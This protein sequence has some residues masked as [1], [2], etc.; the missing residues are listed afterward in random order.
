MNGSLLLMVAVAVG[1]APTILSKWRGH[2]HGV[3]IAVCNVLGL[4]SMTFSGTVAF[5]VIGAALVWACLPTRGMEDLDEK[6]EPRPA[7]S[8]EESVYSDLARWREKAG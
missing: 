8:G 1:F 3:A 7:A 2:H 6:Y 5:L 4:V